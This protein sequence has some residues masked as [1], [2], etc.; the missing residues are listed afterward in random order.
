[1]VK[2]TSGF[3]PLASSW[4]KEARSTAFGEPLPYPTLPCSAIVPEEKIERST[5]NTV[6]MSEALPK[7]PEAEP[8]TN[9]RVPLRS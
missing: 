4:L 1:M 3:D 7:P 8:A 5:E 9:E 2:A 6:L